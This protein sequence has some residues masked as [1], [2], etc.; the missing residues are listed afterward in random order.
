MA[1]RAE[2]GLAPVRQPC[3]GTHRKAVACDD[4]GQ[5]HSQ[6]PIFDRPD[7][8]DDR[9]AS[10]RPGRR[11]RPISLGCGKS[12]LA[13]AGWAGGSAPADRGVSVLSFFEVAAFTGRDFYETADGEVRMNHPLN[14]WMAHTAELWRPACERVA[15]WMARA[16]AE[17]IQ[18]PARPA[19]ATEEDS[20]VPMLAGPWAARL[21]PGG[22]RRPLPI[23][24]PAGLGSPPGGDRFPRALLQDDPVP[25]TCWQCGRALPS[26]R[27]RFC[28]DAHAVAYHGETQW[29]G[30]VDSHDRALCRPQASGGIKGGNR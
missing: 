13:G 25:R 22:F 17:G 2:R 20:T 19:P 23:Q 7:R 28:T 14:A 9:P 11:D 18:V 1:P 24:L 5:L 30:V 8:N 6:F 10:G 3:V 27:R 21:P 26:G 4:P 12:A 16:F 29:R 15:A